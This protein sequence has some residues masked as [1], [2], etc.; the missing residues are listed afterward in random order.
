MFMPL[1]LRI[2]PIEVIETCWS[3]FFYMLYF[4]LTSSYKGD[5]ALFP[6]NYGSWKGIRFIIFFL[7]QYNN[8]II[9]T[10][11]LIILYSAMVMG[12]TTRRATW[13]WAST[14]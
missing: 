1:I 13:F 2:R 7:T 8:F 4:G 5:S 10:H 14:R 11:F 12:E 9:F 6:L 3:V